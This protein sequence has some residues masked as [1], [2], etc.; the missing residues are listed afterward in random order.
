[1][2]FRV[3]SPTL[4]DSGGATHGALVSQMYRNSASYDAGLRPGDVITG[5]NGKPVED[6]S[7]FRK[8]I[9]DSKIGTTAALRVI[10]NGRTIE[11]RV[12]I[13]SSSSTASRRRK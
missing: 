2:D 6:A 3:E 4:E 1:V 5:L 12:P 11:I 7:Q 8:M 9:A 13:E 10:K